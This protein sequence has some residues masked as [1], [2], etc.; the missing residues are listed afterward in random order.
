VQPNPELVPDEHL[1]MW[2][3]YGDVDSELSRFVGGDYIVTDMFSYRSVGDPTT[4]AW[5]ME[6]WSVRSGLVSRDRLEEAHC[7]LT[8]DDL[9]IE[10]QWVDSQRFDFGTSAEARGV[11]LRPWSFTRKHP[12]SDE[13]LVEIQRDFVLYHALDKRGSGERYELVHPLD[14]LD[15]ARVRIEKHAFTIPH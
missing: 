6:E 9:K 4:F 3:N 14:D 8:H 7:I 12:T 1:T 5:E 15:V 11:P 10:P 13:L 2:L